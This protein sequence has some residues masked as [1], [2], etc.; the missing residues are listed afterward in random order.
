MCSPTAWCCSVTS[1]CPY[2][3]AVVGPVHQVLGVVV[4]V[5]HAHAVFAVAE[6]V[7]RTQHGAVDLDVVV[8]LP[9]QRHV[10][11]V[12]LTVTEVAVHAD[13]AGN[14][15]VL[16]FVAGYIV[17]GQVA[18]H[19]DAVFAVLAFL[20][21]NVEQHAEFTG[22]GVP[23]VGEQDGCRGL[24]RVA[25]VPFV[26]GEAAGDLH[27]VLVEGHAGAQVDQATEAS[28]DHLRT[29]VLV[30]VHTAE[31]FGRHV[32]PAQCTAGIG[33]EDIAAIELAAH[34]GEAAHHDAAAFALVAGDLHAGD[35][36]QCLGDVV[37]GQLADVL[38][39]DRINDL[40]AGFL[41]DLCL[42]QA[43]TGTGDLDLVQVGGGR[44]GGGFLCLSGGRKQQRHTQGKDGRLQT[45][46]SAATRAI[47]HREAA[48]ER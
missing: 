43:A 44:R 20:V 30:D 9:L 21:G 46:T 10:L 15:N 33:G 38:G 1:P 8:R 22:F 34:L 25:Q 12:T 31:Q 23:A 6:L 2:G 36:L 39:H 45:A 19:V 4:E 14:D 16:A 17:I 28:F 11:A 27:A 5:A 41:D 32:F 47:G 24:Q 18:A 42:G 48:L 26:E 40:V 35:A 29:G 37:V 7:V 13:F 3:A